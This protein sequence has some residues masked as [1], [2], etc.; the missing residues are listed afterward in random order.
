MNPAIREPQ[1]GDKI[2]ACINAGQRKPARL[3]EDIFVIRY[4]V[5]ASN[6]ST[7]HALRE[8]HIDAPWMTQRIK[9]WIRVG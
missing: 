8:R 6:R 2:R 3:S 9:S 4:F 7:C 1:V 5:N